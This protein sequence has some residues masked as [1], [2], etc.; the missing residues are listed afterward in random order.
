MQ[1]PATDILESELTIFWV[2]LDLNNSSEFLL[3]QQDIPDPKLLSEIAF[4]MLSAASKDVRLVYPSLYQVGPCLI[5]SFP[6]PITVLEARRKKTCSVC[7]LQEDRPVM[8]EEGPEWIAHQ[9]TRSHRRLAAKIK[10]FNAIR[11]DHSTSSEKGLGQ[12]K[13]KV[14]GRLMIH[15]SEKRHEPVLHYRGP[16]K[17]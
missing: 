5:H 10:G 1:T 16:N 2:C 15:D 9:K 3:Q 6:S 7:T 14:D 13:W 12:D 8:I 4:Q 17:R 11:R